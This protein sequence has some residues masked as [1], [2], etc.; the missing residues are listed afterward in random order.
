MQ[1]IF[2]DVKMWSS[3]SERMGYEF[4]SFVIEGIAIDPV[5][6]EVAAAQ[7]TRIV[8]TNRNHYRQ[9]ARVR[10]LTGARVA[11]HPADAEFVTSKGVTVDDSLAIGE[12]IGPLVVVGAAG[13]SPGEIA[14]HWPERRALII[15]D[16]CVGK[17][18]GSLA[19]L[20]RA[21]IDDLPVLQ[22]SLIALAALDVDALL[23]CDGAP[24]LTGARDALLSLVAGF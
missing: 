2:G 3:Y 6:E 19:L 13:K 11:V 1:T 8:L 9:A 23:L 17:P 20:P 24:I 21:V 12:Q 18:A 7:P 16:A 5:V 15:G 4:N 22:E 14:L 10:E